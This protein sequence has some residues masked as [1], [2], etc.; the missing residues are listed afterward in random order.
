MSGEEPLKILGVIVRNWGD[1]VP[2]DCV[3]LDYTVIVIV[4]DREILVSA[5][6]LKTKFDSESHER[7]RSC[8]NEQ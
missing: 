4:H 1:P 5:R 3:P 2:G 7:D 8:G 6:N